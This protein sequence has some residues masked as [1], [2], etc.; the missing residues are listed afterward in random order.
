MLLAREN[1]K[2]KL[3]ANYQQQ[4]SLAVFLNNQKALGKMEQ[5]MKEYP[6]RAKKVLLFNLKELE[7]ME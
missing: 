5:F 7:I 1:E 4:E 2:Y 3:L 6:K